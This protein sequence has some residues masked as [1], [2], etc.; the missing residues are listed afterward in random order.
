MVEIV[1]FRE[2]NDFVKAVPSRFTTRRLKSF[3]KKANF[4]VFYLE[5]SFAS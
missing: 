4:F 5:K 1:K 3:S 2:N